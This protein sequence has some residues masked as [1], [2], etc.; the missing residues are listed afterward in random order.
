MEDLETRL[1][2]RI[3]TSYLVTRKSSELL[4]PQRGIPL[5]ITDEVRQI[6]DQSLTIHSIDTSILQKKDTDLSDEEKKLKELTGWNVFWA[7]EMA[8]A[9]TAIPNRGGTYSNFLPG[10][11]THYEL[12][13]QA[14]ALLF[15]SG[16]DGIKG[17]DV[18]EIGSGSGL[19]LMKLA[20]RGAN[21]TCLD[22]SIMALEFAKYLAGHYT[23]Q[24]KVTLVRGDYFSM[25]QEIAQKQFDVV[26]NSGVL[27]HERDAKG[28][29][30]KMAE[31]TRPDGYVVI[32]VPNEDS[33]F[34]RRFKQR[35]EDTRRRFPLIPRI[36]VE[37]RRYQHDIPKLM[38]ENNL[39]FIRRDGV[40]V[41]ASAPIGKGD[42]AE[43]DLRFFDEYLPLR[44][45]SFPVED[46]INAWRVLESDATHELRLR[47]GWSVYY[48]G[49]KPIEQR[50]AA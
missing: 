32:S 14:I 19:G 50:P 44:P 33:K 3:N 16:Q 25:P 35:E 45:Q 47:Y 37:N 34:Y 9:M 28:L 17:K 21:V 43:H 31:I 13:A 46:R 4:D 15:N 22:S 12:V 5:T 2:E 36:P 8:A 29:V 6:A 11:V 18:T 26:Y 40:Q 27:E 20:Q 49:Q 48:V 30:G 24:D 10:R 7:R 23:V 42:I 1:I 39:I 38:R 41:A